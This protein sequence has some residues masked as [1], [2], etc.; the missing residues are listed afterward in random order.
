MLGWWLWKGWIHDRGRIFV[1]NEISGGSNQVLICGA[2]AKAIR[3]PLVERGEAVPQPP[4]HYHHH[5]RHHHGFSFRCRKHHSWIRKVG[6]NSYPKNEFS[7]RLGT[8]GV[9]WSPPVSKN[10]RLIVHSWLKNVHTVFMGGSPPNPALQEPGSTCLKA[11]ACMVVVIVITPNT[12]IPWSEQRRRGS[13]MRRENCAIHAIK[14][15]PDYMKLV[16]T[17]GPV[18][19][20][21]NQCLIQIYA[22]LER[23]YNN[24]QSSAASGL[25]RSLSDCAVCCVQRLQERPVVVSLLQNFCLASSLNGKNKI[26]NVS[27]KSMVSS[28]IFACSSTR[29]WIIV[30]LCCLFFVWIWKIST[31]W[32]WY[33]HLA[34]AA[35]WLGLEPMAAGS[36][37]G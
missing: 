5:H 13:G 6:R 28:S 35:F 11:Y 32:W 17:E 9:R 34:C 1:T 15:V 27:E 25:E 14:N 18:G 29:R 37:E 24:Q 20:L 16:S 30:L 36:M 4:P 2:I 22:F 31:I 3:I 8:V 10:R 26:G 12:N 21:S 7:T 23:C 19:F 33:T